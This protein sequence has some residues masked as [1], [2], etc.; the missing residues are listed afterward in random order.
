MNRHFLSVGLVVAFCGQIIQAQTTAFT[1]QG[2]L[3]QNGTDINGIY[4]LTFTVFDAGTNGTVV[5][6]PQTNAATTISNG[7]FTV[8]LDFG[9][10]AFTGA[11]RWLEVGVRT[12][13]AGPFTSL[14]P[15]QLVTSAPYAIRSATTESIAGTNIS[16]S[17]PDARL[18]TNVARLNGKNNF[19]GTN[20]FFG[21]NN[22]FENMTAYNLSAY[23]FNLF[24][25]GTIQMDGYAV[26]YG[27]ITSY[28]QSQGTLFIGPP[29]YGSGNTKISL[30][31]DN[32]ELSGP[33]HG[34][35]GGEFN[36]KV[37]F[38][39]G[40]HTNQNNTVITNG[41]TIIDTNGIVCGTAICDGSIWYDSSDRNL[42]ENVES[43]DSMEV[44]QRVA[45]L[46]ISKWNFKNRTDTQHVG[47]MAQDFYAAF[48]LG[49]DD[50]HIAAV[51]AQGVAL[52]AIQGL[53]QKV[54]E[55]DAKIRQLE[56]DNKAL[57][58]RLIQLE[59]LVRQVAEKK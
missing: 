43:L 14:V 47:P 34:V 10:N 51:D 40:L 30:F 39:N 4:D 59:Q 58:E 52:A 22:T 46:P 56:Q 29:G 13:G 48:G 27:G 33:I 28:P 15:R 49:T 17:I 57:A 53:N 2:H 8:Q 54:D 9:T 11:A 55:K 26:M 37:V 35:V 1:Y 50:K 23:T 32:I 41:T 7:L 3:S 21:Y 6:I 31:A 5:S 16:G 24:S 20:T 12:N 38:T 36:S 45:T 44:L 18:S 42:K 25:G 19:T